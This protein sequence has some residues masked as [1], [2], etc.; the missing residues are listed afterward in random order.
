MLKFKGKAG[1]TRTLNDQKSHGIS[2]QAKRTSG[3]RKQKVRMDREEIR[4]FRRIEKNLY[5]PVISDS[6]DALGCRDHVMHA[7]V[8]P[9]REDFAF[10]GRART[11]QW[12]YMYGSDPNPYDVEIKLMDS[13]RPGDV[14]IHNSDPRLSN[15]PWGELMST[16]AKC[17]GARGAIIDSCVRDVKKIFKLN[18][19]VFATAIAPLDSAGRGKVVGYD[20]PIESGGVH[21]EPGDLVVA[22]YDGVAV[23]PKSIEKEVL[24][25]AFEKATKETK[26]RN[27]LRKGRL[28]GEV[29]SKYGVL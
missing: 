9:L 21:I 12:M 1:A 5:V 3:T 19:P 26:T 18:F 14:V 17:R 16:A 29:Y 10:A 27:E 11:A 4:L 24:A 13:L 28:L 15:A 2:H 22:D 8:R 23:I 20:V 25:R 6:L 7:R